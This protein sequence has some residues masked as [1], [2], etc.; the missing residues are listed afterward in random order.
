MLGIRG[1]GS[2]V[3]FQGRMVL[4]SAETLSGTD[5]IP[6]IRHI[7]LLMM[8]NHSFDHYLGTSALKLIEEK[9]NL[10][11]LTRRDAGAVAPWDLIDLSVPP[12]FLHPPALPPP[13]ISWRVVP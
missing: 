2:S 10:P 12:P 4:H 7:V 11:P 5:R 9:W 8:K 1:V 13:T 3:L 6:H